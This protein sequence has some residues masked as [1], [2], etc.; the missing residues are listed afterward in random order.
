MR[1][2][3]TRALEFDSFLKKKV[4]MNS[5]RDLLKGLLEYIEEQA[6]EID[7][8]AYHLSATKGFIRRNTELAGLPGLEFDLRPEGDHIWLHLAR[9]EAHR[10][11]IV[12]DLFRGLFK[13]NNDPFGASTTTRQGR[14]VS[15]VFLRI[16][17]RAEEDSA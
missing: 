15:A 5:P 8:K 11:P 6:K 12:P 17:Y 3:V 2:R 1:R 10:P 16:E 13:V 9:L 7:P 14:R 4:K